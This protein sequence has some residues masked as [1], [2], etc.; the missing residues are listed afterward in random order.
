V[1]QVTPVSRA[2]IACYDLLRIDRLPVVSENG[3][4][5]S[6]R[7]RV[8]AGWTFTGPWPAERLAQV[9]EAV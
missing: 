2:L 1:L 7:H 6:A 8:S 4:P 5:A 3:E 9:Y